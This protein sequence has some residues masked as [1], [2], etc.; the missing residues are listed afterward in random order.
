VLEEAEFYTSRGLFQDARLIL[1]EQLTRTPNHRL[2]IER[3]QE[4]EREMVEAGVVG[5]DRPVA[6]SDAAAS[7]GFDAAASL[8]ALEELGLSPDSLRAEASPFV[9]A[10]QEVDV[11]QVFERFKEGVRAQ[12]D[13]S[14]SS[15][16]YDL[17]VAYKEMGLLPDAIREFE[18]AANDSGRECM[19][20]AMIG[21]IH[22]ELNQLGEAVTA[23]VRGLSATRKTPEQELS[24][25]YDLASVYER[26]GNL[27]EALHYYQKAARH[28]PGYRDVQARIAALQPKPATE[29]RIVADDDEF[30]RV[31]DELFNTK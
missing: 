9:T 21:M 25:S 16:H 3:L 6:P 30:D 11:D 19:C 28:N 5:S 29:K 22:A 7:Q 8:D 2:V 14:D 24:L 13:D 17:G 12:V 15:T 4:L 31:F 18:L 20:N 1:T 26:Q 10:D 27:E 23:Y